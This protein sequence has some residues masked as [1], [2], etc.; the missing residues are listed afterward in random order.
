MMK[1]TISVL[2]ALLMM[3]SLAACGTAGG[4]AGSEAEKNASGEAKTF[5]WLTVRNDDSPAKRA[6]STVIQEYIDSNDKPIDLEFEVITDRPSYYQKVKIL[7]SSNELPDI[8]DAEGDT[9]T[10]EIAQTGVLMEVDDIYKEF[11]YDRMVNIGLN[12]ARLDNGKNYCLNWENNLEYFWY[13]KDLFKQ[14]GIEKTPETYD[15]LLQV[16]QKLKDAGIAP[17]A[18]WGNEAWPLLR[19]MAFIP[20]RLA[21]NDYIESLKKGEAKM[22]DPIGIQAAEFF[23]TMAQNYFMP[24]WSTAG[25]SDAREAFL[26]NNAAMFYIGTWEVP[27]FTNEN[28]ELKDDYDFFYM[29]TLE[30][31]VNGKTDMWS[32]AG[33]GAAITKEAY[34]DENFKGMLKYILD[35][36]PEKAFYSEKLYPAMTFDTSL[37]NMSSLDKKIMDDSAALTSYGYCWDVRMDT[38]STEV[39]TKEIVNLGMGAITPE[40]FA[41]KIDAAIAEN[42]PKY[43]SE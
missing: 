8:F 24:G 37:G 12:Y 32:H 34:E 15:E 1:R 11:G 14:A 26:S 23:Q 33:T 36:F 29:P 39:M 42:A 10:A 2:L 20:F 43:F 30:G 21:G 3:G 22:S 9:L 16:C 31:A 7:A 6:L 4:D 13:H 40:E 18:T 35:Q 17:V 5:H 27:S 41:A 38:A 25:N 19:W 28:R